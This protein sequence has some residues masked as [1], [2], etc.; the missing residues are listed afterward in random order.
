MLALTRTLASA[1]ARAGA[2][3]PRAGAAAARG[4]ASDDAPIEVE[5]GHTGRV[6]VASRRGRGT[7]RPRGAAS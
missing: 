6:L 5:V 4:F 7:W 1:V 3:A 2:A